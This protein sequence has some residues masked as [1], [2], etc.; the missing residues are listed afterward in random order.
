MGRFQKTRPSAS[1]PRP[2]SLPSGEW[3][4]KQLHFNGREIS[5]VHDLTF[6]D[7][8][9]AHLEVCPIAPPIALMITLVRPGCAFI[10][11][12]AHLGTFSML[13]AAL[14]ARVAA[15]EANPRQ[16]AMLAAA[17]ERN[18]FEDFRIVPA[19]ASDRPGTLAFGAWGP[20]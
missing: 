3:G 6:D 4:V 12:G 18:G 11:V 15:I 13:A 1:L 5:V 14:G 19:A 17:V 8:I 7:P 10:D 2:P 9:P 16:A 20:W